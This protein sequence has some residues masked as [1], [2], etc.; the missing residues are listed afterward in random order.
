MDRS[1]YGRGPPPKS[2]DSKRGMP[3]GKIPQKKGSKD[4][5][6]EMVYGKIPI[7][8]PREK[9][10]K[11]FRRDSKGKDDKGKPEK[12]PGSRDRKEEP[13]TTT[14]TSTSTS[15]STT[16][17]EPDTTRAGARGYNVPQEKGQDTTA[18]PPPETTSTSTEAEVPREKGQDTTAGPETTAM[19]ETTTA[20]PENG[21]E[22]QR[23]AKR[24]AAGPMYDSNMWD[25]AD[26]GVWRIEFT[27]KDLFIVALVLLNLVVMAS[28]CWMCAGKRY[29]GYKKGPVV[30]G[31]DSNTEMEM[32]QMV[33]S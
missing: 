31:V 29:R 6:P 3:Y 24:D 10:S 13:D 28:I 22:I 16:T 26:D 32:E 23:G 11:D 5:K 2:K 12:R 14:S 18:P 17:A 25:T 20:A 8:E 19:P 30:Y 4:S 15:T 9:R 1:D 21:I 27:G 33:V 7:I